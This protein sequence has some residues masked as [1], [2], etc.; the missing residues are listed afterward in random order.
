MIRMTAIVSSMVRCLLRSPSSNGCATT[1]EHRRAKAARLFLAAIQIVAAIGIT[2]GLARAQDAP[3]PP[4]T[5]P[6]TQNVPSAAASAG[7]FLLG[8]GTAFAAHEGGH[9]LF[10]AI[11]GASPR[12]EKV[13]F[14]GIPFFAITHD[15]GL[16]DRQEFVIDTAGFWVQEGTNEWLLHKHPDLRHEH[17][18][19]LKGAF[20]F[21]VLAS[22][23]YAGAAFA[24][25]GPPERDTRGM[26]DAL[27]WKEPFVGLLILAP[28]I[29][30]TVRF[31]QPHAKW[32]AWGSRGA[33]ITGVLLV[34][35]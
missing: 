8:G 25:T 10:D 14:K 19:Y 32:A 26:A 13:S 29:L 2:A 20:T 12:L 18:P 21:N 4:V 15:S 31:Y 7:L 17:Q 22:V 33:K 3:T 11:F 23:V 6:V 34:L 16:S 5:P 9:L 35:K 28:A 30:D 24:R 27:H 1:F